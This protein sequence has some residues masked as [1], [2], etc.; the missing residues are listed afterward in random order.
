MKRTKYNGQLTGFC[1]RYHQAVE[2]I[3]RRWSGAII[4]SLLSG[5]RRFSQI[6]ELVPGVSDRLLS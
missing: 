1:P 6:A 3:G 4:R 5:D 2:L